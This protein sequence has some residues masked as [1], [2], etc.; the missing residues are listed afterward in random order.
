MAHDVFICHSVKDKPAADAVCAALEREGIRCWIAPRDILP[1]MDWGE[2]ILEAIVQ[3]RVM[4]L[5]FTADANASAQVHREVERAV[6][7][8]VIILPMRLDDAMPERTLEYFLGNARWIDALTPPLDAHLQNLARS[9]RMLLT[10][11][12][13]FETASSAQAMPRPAPAACATPPPYEPARP[14]MSPPPSPGSSSGGRIR[15]LVQ[16]L[17][18]STK[19][20]GEKAPTPPAAPPPQLAAAPVQSGAGSR[21]SIPSDLRSDDSFRCSTFYPRSIAAGSI[22]KIVASIHLE[23]AAHEVVREAGRRLDLP[24]TV[25]MR[26]MSAAPATPLRLH[27]V[28]DITADVPGL[29]FDA[30]H[31][32]LTVWEERQFV[33]FRFRPDPLFAGRPCQGWLHFWLEGVILASVSISLVIDADDVPAMFKEAMAVAN[34]RPYRLVFPSYSHDDEA[35]VERLEAY[36]ESFGDEYLRDVRRLRTGQRWRE[37]LCGFVRRA[38]VFQLF[39]SE[40]AAQSPYVSDEWQYALLEVQ[41]RPDPYFL[42]PVYWTDSLFPEPPQELR[43]LHFAKVP[44]IR[45]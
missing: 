19:K 8:G 36:A 13:Q 1:G 30:T 42:R 27:S 4:V 25:P 37:E 45:N 7:R 33:E 20:L 15:R 2:S 38:N 12:G 10:P 21:S 24:H 31:A 44:L 26:A 41:S 40:K 3:A 14:A 9:V 29:A 39:W 32:S 18:G 34:A 6:Q 11:P 16:A 35:V 23:S 22:G 43:T 5:L 17:I 28:V